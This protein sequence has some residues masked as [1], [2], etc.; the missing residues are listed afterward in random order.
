MPTQL[1]DV[2]LYGAEYD[3]IGDAI[4]LWQGD[5][6]IGQSVLQAKHCAV[7]LIR[8]IE[9]TDPYWR[10]RREHLIYSFLVEDGWDVADIRYI[11]F[12]DGRMA[13][14]IDILVR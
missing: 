14:D 2:V 9:G 7:R 12:R 10:D 1:R 4:N 11:I 5:K 13:G 3:E 6:S 8:E